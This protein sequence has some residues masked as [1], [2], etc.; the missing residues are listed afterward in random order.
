MG[1]ALPVETC[2][3]CWGDTEHLG[4]NVLGMGYVCGPEINF[5]DMVLSLQDAQDFPGG[6][7]F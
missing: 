7:V 4:L 3:L 1:A 6:D 5:D 2:V